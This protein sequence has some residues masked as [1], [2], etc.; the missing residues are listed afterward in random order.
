M[1]LNHAKTSESQA[2]WPAHRINNAMMAILGYAELALEE[3]EDDSPVRR[4]I[5]QIEIAARRLGDA[6][7]TF[8]ATSRPAIRPQSADTPFKGNVL[9]TDDEETVIEVTQNML[10]R[11]GYAVIPALGGREAIDI[12]RRRDSEVA[13]VLLDCNMP[14]INGIQ[15]LHDIRQIDQS[16]PVILSSGQDEAE[17]IERI[18]G[19]GPDAYVKKP[20]RAEALAAILDR[21]LSAR[22]KRA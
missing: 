17:I 1:G 14:D 18:K 15:A 8:N 7:D 21:L 11:H 5:N 2:K 9:V 22:D 20:Y 16:I 6:D 10:R 13:A 4:Y 12:L 3:L 19:D